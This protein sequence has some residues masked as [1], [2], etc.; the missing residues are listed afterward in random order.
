MAFTLSVPAHLAAE[1]E[2]AHPAMPAAAEQA[3]SLMNSRLSNFAFMPLIIPYIC[4]DVEQPPTEKTFREDTGFT[5][6]EWRRRK[7]DG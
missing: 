4:P 6:H 1:G 2:V 5:P 7:P 3:E